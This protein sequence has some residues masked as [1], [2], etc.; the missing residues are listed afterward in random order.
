MKIHSLILAG[1]LVLTPSVA[2]AHNTK[3]KEKPTVEKPAAPGTSDTD[4]PTTAQP[5]TPRAR[6]RVTVP[7]QYPAPFLPM[8]LRPHVTVNGPQIIL[9]VERG[10]PKVSKFSTCK[11][12]GLP[13]TCRVVAQPVVKPVKP[14]VK[15]PAPVLRLPAGL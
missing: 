9:Q 11:D 1:T 8:T 15:K 10:T 12:Q 5:S 13:L 4:Q 7:V 3:E 14:V 2:L 6:T